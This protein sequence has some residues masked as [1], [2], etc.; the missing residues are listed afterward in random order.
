MGST[1]SRQYAVGLDSSGYLSVNIPWQ[2]N[3]NTAKMSITTLL[4]R[5]S[6]AAGGNY[7]CTDI[8]SYDLI[9]IQSS[10]ASNGALGDI[11]I[12]PYSYISI[13]STNHISFFQAATPSV[14]VYVQ[15][16][17]KTKTTF[18]VQYVNNSNPTEFPLYIAV[19]GL[20]V[21]T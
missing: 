12:F 5:R 2:A 4:S 15:C 17:F 6:V 9:G 3:T 14:S 10:Q 21:S 18:S 8:S 20:K 11:H 7:T 16:G 13:G 19:F 1:A